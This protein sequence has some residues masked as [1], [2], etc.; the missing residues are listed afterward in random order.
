MEIT[1]VKGKRITLQEKDPI[2]RKICISNKTAEQ[3][4]C[5]KYLSYY[6]T[7]ENAKD[8]ITTVEIIH[9]V[10]K[11]NFLHNHIRIKSL[12]FFSLIHISLQQ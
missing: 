1:S 8:I 10:L 4:N 12:Q 3:V 6:I 5:F 7:Y 2:C 9:Q 11:P